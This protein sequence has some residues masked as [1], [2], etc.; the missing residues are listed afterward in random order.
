MTAEYTD[1]TDTA[2]HTS[3]M[4]TFMAAELSVGNSGSYSQQLLVW[5]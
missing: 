2:A 3:N 1:V 5:E 4:N